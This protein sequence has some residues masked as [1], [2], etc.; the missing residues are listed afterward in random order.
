MRVDEVGEAISPN[1]P[2]CA[3]KATCAPK[4]VPRTYLI[5]SCTVVPFSKWIVV[6]PRPSPTSISRSDGSS[7]VTE[8]TGGSNRALSSRNFL[9]DN[10]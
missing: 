10:Q 5:V 3:R 9:C 1:S 2:Q 4:N 6:I 7:A 8:V